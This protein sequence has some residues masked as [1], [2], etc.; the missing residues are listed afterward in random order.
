ME[1][2]PT[3]DE[4]ETAAK[5]ADKLRREAVS[6]LAETLEYLINGHLNLLDDGRRTDRPGDDAVTVMDVAFAVD[7][8]IDEALRGESARALAAKG[9]G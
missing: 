3:K 4:Y 9:P 1:R 2:K 7:S 5:V 6:H 8:L